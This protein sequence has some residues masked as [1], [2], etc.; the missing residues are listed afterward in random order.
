MS[1]ILILLIL[2]GDIY[3][4]VL[5]G[6]FLV[7]IWSNSCP[8]WSY[9][10]TFWSLFGS[11]LNPFWSHFGLFLVT[12]W[13][14]FCSFLVLLGA[15]CSLFGL[16][17]VPFWSIFGRILVH[18]RP[19]FVP[20]FN[21]FWSDNIRTMFLFLSCIGPIMVNVRP[22]FDQNHEWKRWNGSFRNW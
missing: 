3:K 16:F 18:F 13:S 5:F 20:S 8:V 11:L 17:F 22:I 1:R 4:P 7:N 21:I 2:F 12:F 19:D 9:L 14:H 15:F 6:C 10:V